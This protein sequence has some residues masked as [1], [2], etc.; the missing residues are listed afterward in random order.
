MIKI[1][2]M[3]MFSHSSKRKRLNDI[4]I[5]IKSLKHRYKDEH[6]T[7]IMMHLSDVDDVATSESYSKVKA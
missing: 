6:S 3:L 5:I 4:I 7:H 1:K 2:Y